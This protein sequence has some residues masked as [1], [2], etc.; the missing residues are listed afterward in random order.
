[1][2][3]RQLLCG[4]AAVASA[5]AAAAS[6]MGLGKAGL[7]IS[8]TAPVNTLAP[9]IS[10][11]NVYGSTLTVT[12]GTWA[13][14]PTITHQ[15][16][17]AGV[18]IAGQTGLTYIDVLGDVGSII[19][20][21][22]TGTNAF[23]NAT[24]S[25]NG[26]TPTSGSIPVISTSAS[27][28][29]T[30]L[31]GISGGVAPWPDPNRAGVA[32][33]AMG[34]FYA[35]V[36]QTLGATDMLCMVEAE[37]PGGL[38]YVD[39]WYEGT[40]QRLY[41]S[42]QSVYNP[43]IGAM[44]NRVGYWF[45]LSAAG[46]AKGVNNIARVFAKGVPNDATMQPR[47]I[48]WHSGQQGLGS[49]LGTDAAVTG[50]RAPT[51]L[52]EQRGWKPFYVF[53]R[54]TQYDALKRIKADGTGEYTTLRLCLDALRVQL[55][56][57]QVAWDIVLY[58]AINEGGWPTN[59]GA[60]SFQGTAGMP[61]SRIRAL[62]GVTA[63]IR[64]GATWDKYNTIEAVAGFGNMRRWEF[65]S[66][67]ANL[68]YHMAVWGTGAT[69]AFRGCIMTNSTLTT[70]GDMFL[71]YQNGVQGQGAASMSQGQIYEFQGNGF[72]LSLMFMAQ[73]WVTIGY[74][75]LQDYATCRVNGIGNPHDNCHSI[76]DTY[77][78]GYEGTILISPKEMFRVS[79]TGAG[80]NVTQHYSCPSGQADGLYSL[81]VDGTTVASIT[82][83]C[84]GAYT[85]PVP[86]TAV[87]GTSAATPAQVVAWLN[88]GPMTA[89]GFSSV[90][91]AG[92]L[93]QNW[94]AWTMGGNAS[95]NGAWLDSTTNM[96]GAALGYV[97]VF[98][99]S[100]SHNEGT[101]LAGYNTDGWENSILLRQ[102][103]VQCH[104]ST[105]H[106]F[107]EFAPTSLPRDLMFG[108][109]IHWVSNHSWGFINGVQNDANSNP[110]DMSGSNSCALNVTTMD[111]GAVTVDTVRL[112]DSPSRGAD[113]WTGARRSI[114]GWSIG[115]GT[116]AATSPMTLQDCIHSAS[117]A[118]PAWAG[119]GN[120]TYA[121]LAAKEALFRN[122]ALQ[123]MRPDPA[124]ALST[125]MVSYPAI[126]QAYDAFG[127]AYSLTDFKGAVS[128]NSPAFV[129]P[130]STFS[131]ATFPT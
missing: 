19:T 35:F 116:Y 112:H 79:Y 122:F 22:E 128:Q 68:E 36:G 84:P 38:A 28:N 105:G 15:W 42:K 25:S 92:A 34:W 57:G 118:V 55:N 60:G 91:P 95:N 17:K 43:R 74:G 101:H 78:C 119:T 27:Y 26:I 13:G 51:D 31:S 32:K 46:T 121:N 48:G 67:I 76:L 21:D 54:A 100:D 58:D 106:A 73:E 53:P 99:Q 44:E 64:K 29:G 107:F 130:W 62:P 14:S 97:R 7:P 124:G 108:Y 45:K 86:G 98:S 94:A 103:E 12:P 65:H 102:V 126:E 20:S 6:L 8:G 69:H 24:A 37:C 75:A 56:A 4:S 120:T 96:K 115:D 3:R 83:R 104:W 52:G 85:D 93:G 131:E 47:V 63:T 41:R 71:L 72:A 80:A 111:Y 88:G 11:S 110:T 39:V 10:G 18:P 109:S 66:G 50:Y 127:T 123:D 40:T 81:V 114:M 77:I 16:K 87:T 125:Q 33:P 70:A 90:I 82:L 89:L 129:R 113:K 59:T 30:Q 1:M 2:N 5:S 61:T 49:F 23:G 9:T 117:D